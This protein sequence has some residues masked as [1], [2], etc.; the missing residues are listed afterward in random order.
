MLL[1]LSM[2]LF[3]MLSWDMAGSPISDWSWL[4]AS[5]LVSRGGLGLRQSALHA[6]AT[7]VSSIVETLSLVSEVLSSC[8]LPAVFNH[9]IS[10]LAEAAHCPD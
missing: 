10:S 3:S 6:S 4:K 1:P 8:S 9:S 5:L 7:Y 2:V